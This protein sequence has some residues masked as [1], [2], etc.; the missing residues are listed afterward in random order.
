M[1]A[2]TAARLPSTR[3]QRLE[4]AKAAGLRWIEAAGPPEAVPGPFWRLLQA[5]DEDAET[6]GLNDSRLLHYVK[7]GLR[8]L[9]Y[10]RAQG[11]PEERAFDRAVVKAYQ[12]HV[13]QLRREPGR[14]P[15]R[16][17]E[18]RGSVPRPAE[19]DEPRLRG[20]TQEL[21]VRA[22]GAFWRY[23]DDCA[24]PSFSPMPSVDPT[25]GLR[26]RAREQ[27]PTS[28]VEFSAEELLATPFVPARGRSRFEHERNLQLALTYASL[29]IRSQELREATW[30]Q[31]QAWQV[32][33]G[34]A[35]PLR[36]WPLEAVLAGQ[37][38]P[39]DQT[40][41]LFI[42]LGDVAPTKSSEWRAVPLVGQVRERF[43]TYAWGWLDDQLGSLKYLRY[44]SRRRLS[45]P[46]RAM[47]ASRTTRL[48]MCGR[49]ISVAGMETEPVLWR[50]VASLVGTGYLQTRRG[51]RQLDPASAAALR[52]VLWA[53]AASR[54]YRGGL[55]RL[56][57]GEVP[58]GLFAG[59]V[60][61]SREGGPLSDAQ[62]QYIWQQM[63]WTN[64]GW[65][66]QRLRQH[67]F[68]TFE[69]ARWQ[70]LRLIGGLGGHR[71]PS[72]T[73]EHYAARSP[74]LL[75]AVASLLEG[76]RVISESESWHGQPLEPKNVS[77]APFAFDGLPTTSRRRSSG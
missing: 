5:Y 75:A 28:H 66:P 67:V 1:S 22:I 41:V 48:L 76:R 51:A 8:Y 7:Q 30:R 25:V 61:P 2:L 12:K 14:K 9:R 33:P 39:N 26:W 64:R 63:G 37:V 47:G 11:L 73:L 74:W 23:A 77:A 17:G 49:V 45:A 60:F 27:R 3:D 54:H 55:E 58:D 29:P 35:M 68:Q 62:V 21:I 43:L 44:R 15:P 20:T 57:R 4:Q 52:D 71:T 69:A 72:T 50:E 46:L 13:A 36:R 32:A 53:T 70:Q 38:V 59:V 18:C 40:L 42:V 24:D 31:V 56:R 6:L 65:A 34:A 19:S 16:P 10:L